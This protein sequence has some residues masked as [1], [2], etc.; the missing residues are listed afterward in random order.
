MFWRMNTLARLWR[1]DRGAVL[2]VEL[3]LVLAVLVLG[4][5][6]GLAKLRDSINGQFGEVGEAVRELRPDQQV[7]D[8]VKV[9]NSVNVQ[10]SPVMVTTQHV[11]SAPTDYNLVP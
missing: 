11:G 10:V 6:G 1:D 4:V 8:A 3:L 5:A 9:S 7:R 2:S